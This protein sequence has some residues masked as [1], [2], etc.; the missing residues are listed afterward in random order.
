MFFKDATNFILANPVYFIV[1]FGVLLTITYAIM[2]NLWLDLSYMKKKY[3]KMMAG[4]DGGNLERL[5]N[6]HVEEVNMVVNEQKELRR[7]INRIDETLAKAITKLAVVRFDAFDNMANDL[8][9]CVA[10]LDSNNNGIVISGIFGREDAR[11]YVK[12]IV[13]GVS[14]YKLTQE[15]E[16]ALREAMSQK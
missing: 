11:T 1:G 8:S 15:E 3:K 2:I 12:P 4:V 10:M 14:S 7:E 6:G 9:Y 16:K 13:D 5:I